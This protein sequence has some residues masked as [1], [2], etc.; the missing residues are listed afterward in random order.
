M[1]SSYE[2]R[3]ELIL[4]DLAGKSKS[5]MQYSVEYYAL[6]FNVVNALQWINNRDILLMRGQIEHGYFKVTA[7]DLEAFVKGKSYSNVKVTNLYKNTEGCSGNVE[8]FSH[9][10]QII[11]DINAGKFYVNL[12]EEFRKAYLEDMYRFAKDFQQMLVGMDVKNIKDQTVYEALLCCLG[13]FGEA[14]QQIK[15]DK[16]ENVLA[17]LNDDLKNKG[18]DI[19]TIKEDRDKIFHADEKMPKKTALQ[20]RALLLSYA[21]K[22]L[23]KKL[24]KPATKTYADELKAA[25]TSIQQ[26]ATVTESKT[27]SSSTAT[28]I[29]TIARSTTPTASTSN[30]TSSAIVPELTESQRQEIETI[31]LLLA[32]EMIGP[33]DESIKKYKRMGV[34]FDISSKEET[35]SEKAEEETI[36]K[37]PSIS[38]DV[39][40]KE[41]AIEEAVE[42]STS[43]SMPMLEV[44]GG[45]QIHPSHVSSTIASLWN[46]R[47]APS[48]FPESKR[49]K[50]EEK[51]S[52]ERTTEN[53]GQFK[54]PGLN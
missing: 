8:A 52:E 36:S 20:D 28:T 22:H 19:K 29:P 17:L 50:I 7:T 4:N 32:E 25:A 37:E 44:G 14:Y 53:S 54:P 15:A 26:M 31:K 45:V 48:F 18:I 5:L 47:D 10:M 2:Q 21:L 13:L 27:S 43:A 16:T 6:F 40:S 24:N 38:G 33:D 1:K 51:K 35:A 12:Y 3:A 34:T 46:E 39:E 49:K 11:A 42:E 30:T 41:E 9:R 23:E